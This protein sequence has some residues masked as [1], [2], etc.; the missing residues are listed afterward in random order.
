MSNMRRAV[1][2]GVPLVMI[3]AVSA[4]LI[5][6][7]SK[8]DPLSE[9]GHRVIKRSLPLHSELEDALKAAAAEDAPAYVKDKRFLPAIANLAGNLLSSGGSFDAGKLTDTIKQLGGM[10]NM[11][12]DIL[13]HSVQQEAE[14]TAEVEKEVAE[15]T[16]DKIFGTAYYQL[17]GLYFVLHCVT[18]E[19]EKKE[20]DGDG[21]DDDGGGGQEHEIKAEVD[22]VA[23]KG[24]VEDDMFAPPGMQMKIDVEEDPRTDSEPDESSQPKAFSYPMGMGP[25]LMNGCF[26]T[27]YKKGDPCWNKKA[28]SPV[29]ENMMEGCAYIGVGFDGRGDY[30]STSRRKTV[31]QRN[32]KNKGSY[33]NEDVP[34]TMNVH[35]IFDTDVGSYVFESR[36]AYRHSLQ[37]KAG[38]SFSGFGFQAAV[39]SAYG[40]E[41]SS[42][43]QSF[44]SLIQCDVIRYEIF[45]D[46][47]TP[48]TLSLP[49]LR[50]FL[51]LPKNFIEGKAKLQ[52][53]IIRYGTHFIKSAKFGG[54][55]RL[56]KTQEA[57]KSESMEDFSIQAQASYNSL[58]F[59]AGGHF[60]MGMSS[61]SSQSSKTSNT[62]VT[63]E[64]GDQEVASIVADFYSTGFK[65]TFVE[66][67]KSIPTYPKPIE[68]FMGTMSELLDMNYKLLFP[69]DISDAAD[70]CFSE[71]LKTEGITGR[72]YYEVQKLVNNSNGVMESATEKRY[73][74]FTSVDKFQE[75]LDKKRLALERAIVM[76]MEEGPVPTTDFRLTG[77]KPGCTTEDLGVKGGSSGTTYP[78]WIELINGDTYKIIFDIPEN[79]NYEITK[80]TEAFLVYAR[81]K[82]NCHT[83]GSPMHMYNSRNNGGSGDTNNK[84]VSC[85][86]FVMTYDEASG[87]FDVTPQDQDASKQVLGNL[88]RNYANLDVARAE[89]VSP[90]E[91]SQAKGGRSLA[92]ILE[93]PCTVKWSNSYQIKPAEEGGKCL[94]FVAASSGDIFVVFSAIPRDKTTWYHL[95][96]SYQGVALYKGM[97]L[98]KYEGAKN[99]RSLGDSKLFQP[100]FIC[101]E[102][103]SANQRTYIK[104]GIGSDTSEKGL[105]YM[106]YN[107][108]GPPLG[109]RFY[110]F[111]S[112]EKDVEIMDARIIEGGAQGEME[113]TGGTVMKDGKCVE[114]CH[115][116]CNGCIP[117]SPGSKLDTEC[118][119]C[120]HFSLDKGGGVI[121]CVAECPAGTEPASDG[122]TCACKDFVF[123]N[124]DGSS[125]CVSA[126]GTGFVPGSDGKTCVAAIK[127]RNDFR[128]GR[129]F[130]A[131]GA[132]PGRCNPKSNAPCCSNQEGGRCGAL[133]G[134][135][136][137]SK[138]FDFRKG[139]NVALLKP[140]HQ[141][142]G[143]APASR[144]VDGDTNSDFGGNSCTHS[145]AENSPTWYVDLGETSKV[146]SVVIY[147]RDDCCGD[148]LNPFNIHI[149][150]FRTVTDN[151][152]CGGDQ[153]ID[154]SKPSISV[155]CPGMRGRYVGIRLPG[156]NRILALCEVQVF[157]R[158]CPEDNRIVLPS[159]KTYTVPE[160]SSAYEGAQEECRRQGGI[161]AIPRDE[162][163]QRNLVFLKNCVSRDDQFWLGMKKT[164]GVWRDGRGT[165]LGSFTSWA[166]GEPNNRYN[167]A[168]IVFGDK[169]GERRDKW[170]GATC[171]LRFRYVC[172][173][174]DG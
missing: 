66:W 48:D 14:V 7:A 125:R 75:G 36:Q 171:L 130:P 91:H 98:V 119:S 61:G 6:T 83:A 135:C 162:E 35:G 9:P 172:E 118:R 102:E 18:A 22:F 133:P 134:H 139:V 52:R 59:N 46:E 121:Q 73:C 19:L 85:F 103:D 90:L 28:F 65:D 131:P 168:H 41:S 166:S 29:C 51:A 72:K 70:G 56:F 45:L 158:I 32:C 143:E 89:Y 152:K 169:E 47:I 8:K 20:D 132:S 93:A 4:Y 58:F 25:A 67:L 112:G 81:G 44:M 153:R 40:K 13:A 57:S 116:E 74:D 30:S 170:A 71:N 1:G 140:A 62:H 95:Q 87:T 161:V 157:A 27:G 79:I 2:V 105:V 17:F 99:A 167:C 144:A 149:G 147:N 136:G 100:Y 77:G 11:G 5:L 82:W 26:G 88:P 138:C 10:E 114:N 64:G 109:I 37:M 111:G 110:S 106:V 53:F 101:L 12:P 151:P 42:Q 150:D 21:D 50:D 115:P 80:N 108:V 15:D 174:Q 84:K 96:I 145:R 54:S 97:K 163:E 39:E 31:V 24:M 129:Q 141:S 137:C 155:S 86:G 127:W 126:C 63:V 16:V 120:K 60:G 38:V 113:C 49:F 3:L 164:A 159:G 69:F 117:M 107:D 160:S 43:K 128:C 94:Y 148:R 104:Y 55:F 68:M 23:Q 156:A 173:I 122:K 78:K 34:D 92:A 123:N 146:T 165:A 154:L 142:S 76:Y 124:D 33:R